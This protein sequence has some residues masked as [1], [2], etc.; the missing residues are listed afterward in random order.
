M[1]APENLAT[2]TGFPLANLPNIR[3]ERLRIAPKNCDS[4]IRF[5][6]TEQEEQAPIETWH[7]QELLRDFFN[8]G[9]SV[10]GVIVHGGKRYFYQRRLIERNFW[11]YLWPIPVESQQEAV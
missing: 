8:R 7:D 11:W 4:R 9:F 3:F 6:V 5:S 10:D 1:L 2:D